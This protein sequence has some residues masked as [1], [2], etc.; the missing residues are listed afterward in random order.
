MR[1][2][3]TDLNK[4]KL[5]NI[6]DMGLS[7]SA[8]IRLYEKKSKQNIRDNILKILDKI[9]LTDSDDQFENYHEH[10]CNWGIKNVVLAERVRTD[11]I[12]KES[13]PASYGQNQKH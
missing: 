5:F 10:F 7:F 12:I 13:G 1:T 3:F 8:M 4:I 11:R 9:S 2:E 6:V